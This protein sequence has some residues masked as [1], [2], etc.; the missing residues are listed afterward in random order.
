MLSLG[1][2]LPTYLPRH[3]AQLDTSFGVIVARIW[4]PVDAGLPSKDRKQPLQRGNNALNLFGRSV[5]V[6]F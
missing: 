4:N 3:D 2:C 6:E 1:A 5:V